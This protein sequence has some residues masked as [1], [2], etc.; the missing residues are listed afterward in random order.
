MF[1]ILFL[2]YILLSSGGLL[3]MKMGGKET[4]I[5]LTNSIIESKFSFIFLLGIFCYIF[6]FL[7]FIFILQRRNLSY[8]YPICTGCINIISVLMGIF[9]LQEKISVSGLL[10]VFMIGFGIFLINLK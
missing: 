6:S 3:L 4:T 9:I 1:V 7:V 8:I 10:G 5:N 2:C